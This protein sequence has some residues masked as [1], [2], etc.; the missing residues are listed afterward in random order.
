MSDVRWPLEYGSTST[1]VVVSADLKVF[2]TMSSSLLREGKV[3]GR[4]IFKRK[5]CGATIR[6]KVGTKR[7]ETLRSSRKNLSLILLVGDFSPWIVS[8]LWDASSS[9]LGCITK[10]R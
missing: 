1:D 8:R 10:S 3:A 6:A 9:I 5:L 7:R 4:S 2:L